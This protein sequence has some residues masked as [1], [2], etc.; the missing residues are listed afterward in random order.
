V[1]TT[2]H[3]GS[4]RFLQQLFQAV[5]V[6]ACTLLLLV[7]PLTA[8]QQRGQARTG[9]TPRYLGHHDRRS[10]GF[11]S[12]VFS[13]AHPRTTRKKTLCWTNN[14]SS[15]SPLIRWSRSLIHGFAAVCEL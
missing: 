5:I 11:A 4:F 7:E 8:K 13:G 15:L 6:P 14:Y 1:T 10:K 3:I 2:A 12:P 9:R